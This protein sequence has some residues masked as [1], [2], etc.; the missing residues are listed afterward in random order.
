[1]AATAFCAQLR[2]LQ[3]S[4]QAGGDITHGEFTVTAVLPGCSHPLRHTL[5]PDLPFFFAG[6]TAST[7]A[8]AAAKAN[9]GT[10]SAAEAAAAAV[11][12]AAV[13]QEEEEEEDK[14]VFFTDG[15]GTLLPI[16]TVSIG[17]GLPQDGVYLVQHEADCAAAGG[18]G[19]SGT[20]SGN[21]GGEKR[22]IQPY[23]AT[24][25]SPLTTDE[26]RYLLSLFVLGGDACLCEWPLFCLCDK[27]SGK[28]SM[29]MSQTDTATLVNMTLECG[30]EATS[31]CTAKEAPRLHDL[32]AAYV[33]N[34]YATATVTNSGA[35][36]GGDT[37]A[38]ITSTTSATTAA[39]EEEDEE[40]STEVK[41]RLLAQAVYDIRRVSHQCTVESSLTVSF[42]WD[43]PTGVLTSPP[44]S[45]QAMLRVRA[46]PGDERSE[47]ISILRDLARVG[48][49]LKARSLL[50]DILNS[51]EDMTPEAIAELSLGGN[52]TCAT[53]AD[54][55]VQQLQA[56]IGSSSIFPSE[57]VVR[58]SGAAAAGTGGG[59][60]PTAGSA[61][62]A[63]TIGVATAASSAGDGKQ[64]EA[65]SDTLT[66]LVPRADLDFIERLW[67]VIKAADSLP[68]LRRGLARVFD[69]L[70]AGTIQPVLRRVN[71]TAMASVARACLRFNCTPSATTTSS[72]SYNT[73]KETSAF[74][75]VAPAPPSRL[76]EA[77]AALSRPEQCLDAVVE[78][79]IYKVR[80]DLAHH[81]VS[82]ELATPAQL[83]YFIDAACAPAEQIDRLR[84]LTN[85]LEL[86]VVAKTYTDLPLAGSRELVA[87]A[88][89]YY[90]KCPHSDQTALFE[91]DMPAFSP[92]A[93]AAKRLC[94]SADPDFW[95]LTLRADRA[96]GGAPE[97]HQWSNT[98][99]CMGLSAL[100]AGEAAGAGG[101]L[102][103][104]YDMPADLDAASK[105]HYCIA[106]RSTFMK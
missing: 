94:S 102:D 41:P 59:A 9:G 79:G 105:Y 74:S 54:T 73:K 20:G 89:A 85:V 63:T 8:G 48:D 6:R 97:L 103:G 76:Q 99:G 61:T 30:T 91:L 71:S 95:S 66:V 88:L 69:A 27:Q 4:G 23:D 49:Y 38:A 28:L 40:G 44:F 83:T 75:A 45:A 87:A 60:F 53:A 51:T 64:G 70:R 92:S 13:L 34:R 81:L 26:S 93:A 46:V 96:G 17:A 52:G 29:G 80:Q 35:T 12:A 77:L 11:V 33:T 98:R 72:S 31:P 25:I 37:T 5:G 47:T 16:T 84:R 43:E 57:G 50:A 68:D 39:A 90:A 67:R 106:S 65:N 86:F 58:G 10:K 78:V 32:V 42:A 55:L 21:G 101:A 56:E 2:D 15:N 100:H 3:A 1:M 7:T 104:M 36:A 19:A 18:A 24:R 82:Q 14:C 62:S 22:A